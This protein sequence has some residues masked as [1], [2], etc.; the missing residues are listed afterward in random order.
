MI[1]QI[2]LTVKNYSFKIKIYSNKM[3]FLRSKYL[4][5]NF[6]RENNFKQLGN[7]YFIKNKIGGL[8]N[9]KNTIPVC[10]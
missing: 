2:I 3:H 9:R 4:I 1:F 5:V 7:Y 8:K 10:R 6:K